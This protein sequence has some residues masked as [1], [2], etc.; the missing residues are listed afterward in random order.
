M[1]STPYAWT[2]AFGPLAGVQV[3]EMSWNGAGVAEASLFLGGPDCGDPLFCANT[4]V[5]KVTTAARNVTEIMK[6]LSIFDAPQ[7]V[8]TRIFGSNLQF[9]QDTL[10]PTSKQQIGW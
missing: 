5:E 9:A 1:A 3:P 8:S 7:P 6:R 2:P 4:S 10:L